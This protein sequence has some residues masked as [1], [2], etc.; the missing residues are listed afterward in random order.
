MVSMDLIIKANERTLKTS[1][2]MR[3]A[4]GKRYVFSVFGKKMTEEEMNEE[5]TKAWNEVLGD[6][7][8]GGMIWKR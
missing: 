3:K 2:P 1:I 6:G 7:K 8:E 4:T 5:F